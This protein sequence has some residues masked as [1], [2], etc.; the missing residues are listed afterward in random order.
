MIVIFCAHSIA[1]HFN[2]C[3]EPNGILLIAPFHLHGPFRTPKYTSQS[4][5]EPANVFAYYRATS[6]FNQ[7]PSDQRHL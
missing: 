5:R 7:Q 2:Q 3:Y 4:L 1:N 6:P